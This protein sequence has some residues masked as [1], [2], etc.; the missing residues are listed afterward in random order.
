MEI[1][2]TE[3][4]DT[5]GREGD[6][7]NVKPGY[8][9]N[10]LIPKQKALPVN[11]ATLSRL[12]KEQQAIAARIEQQKKTAE[13]LAAQLKGKVVEIARRVGEEDRLFGSVTTSDIAD[14]LAAMGVKIDRKT[15]Q[16]VDPIKSL[17]ETK[18][19]VKVGYQTTADITVQVIPETVGDGE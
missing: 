12:N 17:G 4:I 5:L 15:I 1:I 19:S 11:K 14:R 18:V 8:A 7:V 10:F 3:T 13:N 6:I 9:R 16:L 2:L